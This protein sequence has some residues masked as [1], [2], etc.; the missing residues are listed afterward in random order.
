MFYFA[1]FFF[2]SLAENN[3]KKRKNY[4]K[5]YSLNLVELIKNQFPT[6]LK[7]CQTHV[8]VVYIAF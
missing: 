5:T 8:E 7:T 4:A 2:F 3:R 1:F 6:L